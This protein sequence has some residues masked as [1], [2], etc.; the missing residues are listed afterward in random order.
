[1]RKIVKRALASVFACA[2]TLTANGLL[3]G[4]NATSL[5]DEF[6][7]PG[8]IDK[9]G[10]VG[11]TIELARIMPTEEDAV[12]YNFTVLN[13]NNEQIATNGYAFL[14]E[15]AGEFKCLY[16]YELN[17][18]KYE[19]SYFVSVSVKDGPVFANEPVFP[20]AFLSGKEYKIPDVIATDYTSGSKVEATVST[21]VTYGGERLTV[22]DGV[23]V[24]VYTN[25]TD[26]A[27]ITYT[28][29][30][31][32]KVETLDV[33]VPVVK[34]TDEN[35]KLHMTELF[36]RQGFETASADEEKLTFTATGNA[37]A[38]FAN[39]LIANG[40]DLEFGFGYNDQAESIIVTIQSFEDPSVSLNVEFKKGN[41]SSGMGTVILNGKTTQAYEYVKGNS[42]RLTFDGKRNQFKGVDGNFLFDVFTDS[43]G[44]EFKGFPG[45][46]VTLGIE[47][48]NVYGVCDLDVIKVNQ[49]LNNSDSEMVS[50]SLYLEEKSSEYSVGD[51]VT[52]ANACAYDVINPNAVLRVTVQKGNTPVKD[53]NGNDIRYMI[54]EEGKPISFKAETSGNYQVIYTTIDP[55]AFDSNGYEIESEVKKPIRV[56]DNQPPVI[57][58]DGKMKSSVKVGSSLTIPKITVSD[59]DG[60]KNSILQVCMIR[61]TGYIDAVADNLASSSTPSKDTIEATTYKFTMK[62]DYRLLIVATDQYGNYQKLEY[63][64]KCE[65]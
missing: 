15:T 26:K 42:L 2:I 54:M 7:I 50:P 4:A 6:I 29:T 5:N 62:G 28:A 47:V 37:Q 20:N 3:Y 39:K 57:T 27:V 63:V 60:G 44:G 51:V 17:G 40:L 43:K 56:Y 41:R 45:G 8:L 53:L 35:G 33:A 46:V 25:A 65:G 12:N 16:S 38:L 30:S 64:I 10:F 52:I 49:Y 9:R 21:T 34:V 23:F 36:A 18:Q 32:N 11:E 1:M 59:N 19:Y 31:G 14:P 48:K 55:D 61:P 13:E 22:T 58:L 24:P